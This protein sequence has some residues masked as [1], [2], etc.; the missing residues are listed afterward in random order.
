MNQKL[1]T[2]IGE[3]FEYSKTILIN[4]L[5]LRKLDAIE[6]GSKLFGLIAL[7]VLFAFI[8]GL[9]VC[10]GLCAGV[11][12]LSEAIGS[13][14]ISIAIISLFLILIAVLLYVFRKSIIIDPIIHLF[15]KSLTENQ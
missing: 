1:L 3:N 10:L 4:E 8:G 9:I 13:I 11:I 15:F 5:E 2:D 14:M 12:L 6:S 7:G